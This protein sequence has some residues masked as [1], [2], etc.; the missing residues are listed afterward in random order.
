M[1][2]II[3]HFGRLVTE[4]FPGE[5]GLNY[6]TKCSDLAGSNYGFYWVDLLN[7]EEIVKA[8]GYERRSVS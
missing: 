1:G 3:A 7:E 5:R 8:V 2:K 4:R 6:L